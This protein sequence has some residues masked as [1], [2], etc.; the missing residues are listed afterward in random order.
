M[1]RSI[2]DI[3]RKYGSQWFDSF[4]AQAKRH[5]LDG[6]GVLW[7]SAEEWR[8][9]LRPHITD[10]DANAIGQYR[11]SHQQPRHEI[12]DEEKSVDEIY[13]IIE[14]GKNFIANRIHAETYRSKLQRRK[15]GG[16]VTHFR[17]LKDGEKALYIPTA[18]HLLEKLFQEEGDCVK[19]RGV[20]TIYKMTP[21]AACDSLIAKLD[22]IVFPTDTDK[23]NEWVS[24]RDKFQNEGKL[25]FKD[26]FW[27]LKA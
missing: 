11:T 3:Y 24:V 10:Y 15:T 16:R 26:G 22:N 9:F 20:G 17:L 4:L 2:T 23:Y 1:K 7:L 25:K 18:I 14:R 6:N 19:K 13:T 12:A 8:L 21:D 5:D 27:E